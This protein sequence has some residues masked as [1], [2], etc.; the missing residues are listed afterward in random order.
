MNETGAEAEAAEAALIRSQE[1]VVSLLSDFVADS[2]SEDDLS[3]VFGS[4]LDVPE[5]LDLIE[6]VISDLEDETESESG[7]EIEVL[8]AEEINNASGAFAADNSTIYLSEEFLV[9]NADNPDAIAEEVIDG[10]GHFVDSE[11]NEEDTA[12]ITID[13]ENIEVEQQNSIIYVDKDATAGDE[14]GL[15]W[16]NAYTDLQDALAVQG[17]AIEFG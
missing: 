6:S 16:S 13:G 11:A 1:N 15:S 14:T 7:I 8:P 2:N 10:V 5:A 3:E 9:E 4:Q 17:L 12:A